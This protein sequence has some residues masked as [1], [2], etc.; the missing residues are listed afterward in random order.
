MSSGADLSRRALRLLAATFAFAVLPAPAALGAALPHRGEGPLSPLLEALAD[1]AVA[2]LPLAAQDARL[3][4]PR[5][6]PGGLMRDGR[7][8]LV[9]V[10]FDSRAA[11]RREEIVS[12]GGRVL[13]ASSHRSATVAVPP[14]RLG[15]LAAA[16][17]VAAVSPIRRPLLFAVDCEGGSK[18]SEGVGQ[19]RA[20]VA[21]EKFGLDGSGVT[22]GVLSDSYDRAEGAATDAAEDVATADLPG[23]ANECSGQTTPVDVIEDLESGSGT[24][25][26]R[27]M[28]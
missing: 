12:A 23:A 6:G 21:R 22:V 13:A 25:E 3:G 14:A 27:A 7:R 28:L 24:D 4:L 17:G 2:S 15:A 19:L 20:K 10:R 11:R 18:I 5:R 26:G 16:S 1:P 8:T 9:R